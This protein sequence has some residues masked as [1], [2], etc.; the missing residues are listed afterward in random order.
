M[1]SSEVTDT[2]T[3]KIFTIVV[4]ILTV[5]AT[6]LQSLSNSLGYGTRSEMFRKSADVYDKLLTRVQFEINVPDENDF[7]KKMEEKILFVK[8]E[9]KFLPPDWMEKNVKL[10]EETPLLENNMSN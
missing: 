7:L 1:A 5:I 10:D 3:G 4:G 9:C 2:D 6:M 8:D